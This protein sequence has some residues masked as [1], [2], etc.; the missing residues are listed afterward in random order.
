MKGVCEEGFEAGWILGRGF[1]DE[2]LLMGEVDV[3]LV[4]EA[5]KIDAGV[6]VDP[7]ESETFATP[8][9]IDH[10]EEIGFEIFTED[11]AFE[12]SGGLLGKGI[13]PG[14]EK[15]LKAIQLPDLGVLVNEVEPFPE[16]GDVGDQVLADHPH[17]F[18]DGFSG[19]VDVPAAKAAEEADIDG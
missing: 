12:P 6:V 10:R 7:A 16:T 1:R 8:I 19:R 5:G 14:H 15:S 2:A 13:G 11:V 4:P 3:G 17:Q 9:R 18:P